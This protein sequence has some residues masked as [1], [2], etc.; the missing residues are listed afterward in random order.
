MKKKSI[1][2]SLIIVIMVIITAA[3]LS[4]E[5]IIMGK[6]I[7]SI[8]KLNWDSFKLN[9]L[10]LLLL[11]LINFTSSNI[12]FILNYD[13]G[14]NKF[15]N[16]K[17]EIFKRD[18]K[19][20]DSINISNYTTDA[21]SLYSNRFML[22]I[23]ALNLFFTMF[24]A[25]LSIIYINFKLL[26]VAIFGASLPLLVPILF[27]KKIQER[28]IIFNQ[29]YN[30]YQKYIGRKIDEKDEYIRYKV[31]DKLIEEK[32]LIEKEHEKNR[33]D[34]KSISTLSNISSQNMGSLSF[35]LVFFA[36]GIFAFRG[37]IEVG[38]I[39]SLIQLMNYLVDPIV[40]LSSIIS[41]Y[42]ESKPLYEKMKKKLSTPLKKEK[43]INLNPPYNLK[44]ENI[45]FSYNKDKK[46]LD[47]F[48]KEFEYGKK[49]LLKGESGRGKSTLAKIIAGELKPDHGQVLLNNNDIYTFDFRDYILY[50]DQKPVIIDA[51]LFENIKFYRNKLD[52]K[53]DLNLFNINKKLSDKVSTNDG[54]S[55][56][57]MMRISLLRSLL[58]PRDIM[59]YDEPIASL[60]DYNSKII[61]ERLLSLKQTVIIISHKMTKEDLEKFDEIIDI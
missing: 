39:I 26:P 54:I 15:I 9:L 34:L 52:N 61:I 43:K 47:N 44:L 49:Y 60:D 30:S 50:I 45:S 32:S 53:I 19:N 21:E 41:M 25:M 2:S 27:G 59:I 12:A 4:I 37:E 18:I 13:I 20:N 31:E 22:K 48:S 11:I 16:Y 56:G 36:G 17:N 35:I 33:K 29:N 46:I 42:N 55:G 28:S 38:S 57:E 7:T 24:F 6:I 58:N 3:T 40:A 8:S 10:I 1:F 23:N 5:G 51:N 14:M